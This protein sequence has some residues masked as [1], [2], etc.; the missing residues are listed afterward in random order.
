MKN[1]VFIFMCLF[2][3]IP[4]QAEI[5]YVDE[6]TPNNSDGSSWTNAYKFLQDALAASNIGDE[7]WVAQG[8]CRPDE[9]NG[10]PG[11]TGS[12]T[13]TFQLINGVALYGGFPSGGG[14]W[15]SR[16]PDIYKT[17][18]S[19]D[20]NGD[21]GPDFANN[22]ENSYNVV[23]SSGTDVTTILDGFTITAGNGWSITKAA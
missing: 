6:N 14:L 15:T 20:L 23:D 13:A 18:L 11:G 9:D 4:V 5:I 19:G 1:L 3:V 8:T 21:D 22:G 16:N 10:N 12:R 2:F 17:I 7:I